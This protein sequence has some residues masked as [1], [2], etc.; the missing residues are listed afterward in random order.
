MALGA[1]PG[2]V[3]RLAFAETLGPVVV[4]LSAGTVAALV[5][6]RLGRTLLYGIGPGD[7]MT[8]VG[9]ALILAASALAAGWLPARRA[10]RIDPLTA[11]RDE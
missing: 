5:V 3:M 2:Q 1:R 9:G 6:A 10:S 8:F 11:L 4:G 7:P